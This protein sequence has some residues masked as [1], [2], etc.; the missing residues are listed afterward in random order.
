MTDLTAGRAMDRLV[1]ERIFG[2]VPCDSW[3]HPIGAVP[4]LRFK[5]SCPHNGACYSAE[6]GPWPY[7]I[8]ISAAWWIVEKML[9]DG[10]LFQLFY[11]KQT[12]NTVRAEFSRVNSEHRA[13]GDTATEAICRAAL[14]ARGA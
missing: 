9:A 11:S 6:K 2:L 1:A 7:S 10:W 12:L 13:Y 4:G 3:D 5:D 14:K 8:D